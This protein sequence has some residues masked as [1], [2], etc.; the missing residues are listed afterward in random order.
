MRK[1]EKNDS[2]FCCKIGVSYRVGYLRRI[3]YL[4]S[5][6]FSVLLAMSSF[7]SINASVVDVADDFDDFCLPLPP[8]QHNKNDALNFAL[9]S[10]PERMQK[11]VEQVI[12]LAIAKAKEKT[13]EV[14]PMDN[15]VE[16]YVLPAVY[17]D[18]S[19]R[20]TSGDFIPDEYNRKFGL[21]WLPTVDD[22][23]STTNGKNTSRRWFHNLCSSTQVRH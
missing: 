20:T 6:R 22:K 19:E 16:R 4:L 12:A 21:H 3:G 13:K 17:I 14:H 9:M 18:V 10:E 1:T 15:Y 5:R 2:F 23:P 7:S 11:K 8:V